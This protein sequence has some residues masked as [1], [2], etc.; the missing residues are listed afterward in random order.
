MNIAGALNSAGLE[1]RKLP[2]KFRRTAARIPPH[3]FTLTAP[4]AVRLLRTAAIL[5]HILPNYPLAG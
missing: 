1:L 3:R 5:P 4:R 2:H